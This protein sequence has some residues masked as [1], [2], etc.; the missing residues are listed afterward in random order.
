MGQQGS[1]CSSMG[2]LQFNLAEKGSVWEIC[3][4]IGHLGLLSSTEVNVSQ[5]GLPGVSLGYIGSIE[6]IMGQFGLCHIELV[7]VIQIRRQS[8]KII[9]NVFCVSTRICLLWSCA[10]TCA[11]V[12]DWW[13]FEICINCLG[14]GLIWSWIMGEP[15]MRH[16]YKETVV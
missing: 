16:Q 14:N 15:L 12:S 8:V 9:G 5:L 13:H 10:D 2:D 6:E 7:K 1:I 11:I 4:I 3:E